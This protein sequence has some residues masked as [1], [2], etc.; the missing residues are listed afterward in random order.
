M[1]LALIDAS[2]GTPHA[3]RNFQREVDATLTIY[4]ANEGEIPPPIGHPEPVETDDGPIQS[5]DGVIISGSQSSVYDDNR[6]WIQPLSRWV[7]GAI[8]DDV[9]LLGVCWGHQLL[10]QILGG[11]VKGG[12]YELGYVE[13]TQET[14]DPIWTNIPNPF[15]V[16]ATHSDHVVE[17]PP[18]ATLLA[19]NETGV[20]AFRHE[21]V[22]TVQFHPEYDR[23]TATAMIH[24]K[25]T[26]SED[27][28]QAALDTC[29][30]A[31]V[32]AARPAKRIFDNFLDHVESSSTPA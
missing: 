28:V 19:S 8:A 11:T 2:L 10:A 16:F 26:L 1:H 18:G 27:E 25:T 5:F 29:T 4:D 13:V 15:T 3:K 9:P 7:E 31:N 17:M 30:D 21:Q 24:S 32:E 14:E 23:Q 22:Y 20:Q 6:P 12:S